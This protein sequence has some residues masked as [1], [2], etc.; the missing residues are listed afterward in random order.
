MTLKKGINMERRNFFTSLLAGLAFLFI[1]RNNINTRYIKTKRNGNWEIDSFQNIKPG[2]EF[3]LFGP[4]GK[5]HI[6]KGNNVFWAK[7]Y[8]KKNKKNGV[9]GVICY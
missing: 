8:P 7:G 5:P 4:D 3:Q 6:Y 9:W 2:T 1:K